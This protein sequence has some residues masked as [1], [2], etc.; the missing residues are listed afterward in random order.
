MKFDDITN[1]PNYIDILI[2]FCWVTVFNKFLLNGKSKY[3]NHIAQG[4]RAHFFGH[5]LK[6]PNLPALYLSQFIGFNAVLIFFLKGK[7]NFTYYYKLTHFS[8]TTSHLTLGG[9]VNGRLFY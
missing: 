5:V 2:N 9:D 1:Y 6:S 3:N 7:R 4:S 8:N